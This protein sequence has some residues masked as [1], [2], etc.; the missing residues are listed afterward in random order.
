MIHIY[1]GINCVRRGLHTD[2]TGRYVRK[3]V[4]DMFAVVGPHIWVWDGN[5]GNDRR[6][7]IYPD[8]KLGRKPHGDDVWA[9]IDLLMQVLVH[10]PAIQIKVNGFEADDVIADLTNRF[11]DVYIHSSDMDFA[12]LG[13]KGDFHLKIP[14]EQVRLYKTFVGDPR[15]NIPGVP[16]FG[17]KTW[18]TS[19]KTTLQ[20]IIDC[21]NSGSICSV[22]EGAFRPSVTKWL[23]DPGNQQKLKT[24]WE[25]VGFIPIP[26]ELINLNTTAG[27][28]D[29]VRMNEVLAR[30]ML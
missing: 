6:R 14:A 30:F 16:L 10:T 23:Q 19:S 11:G 28:P 22:E 20:D 17:E 8:Y 21:I 12:Q 9:T 7:E 29:R 5:G 24:Y 18:E 27:S 3:T 2:P 13:V 1:D 15:D 26:L 25:I 4:T